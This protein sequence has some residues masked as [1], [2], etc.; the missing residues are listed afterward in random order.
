MHHLSK[1]KIC[2]PSPILPLCF[3]TCLEVFSG[4]KRLLQNFIIYYTMVDLLKCLDPWEISGACVLK[5]NI[6]ISKERLLHLVISK[7]S[8]ILCAN[9]TSWEKLSTKN[10]FS[11]HYLLHYGRLIKMFGPLRNFRCMHFEAKHHYFKRVITA[12][13][14]FKNVTYT[15][16][17]RHQLREAWELSTKN[18]FSFEPTTLAKTRVVNIS[19]FSV[20]LRDAISARLD[21]QFWKSEKVTLTNSLKYDEMVYI[22]NSCFILEFVEAENIPL[23]F[24]IQYIFSFRGAWLLAGHLCICNKYIRHLHA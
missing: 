11:F 1:L 2:H 15:M 22:V 13:G 7:M 16:C 14:N 9:V 20:P 19:C 21:V 5:P 4:K 23:Y 8:H 17:K 10:I 12:S 24:K 6:T 3:W 18:I